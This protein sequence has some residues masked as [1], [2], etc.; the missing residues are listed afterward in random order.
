MRSRIVLFLVVATAALFVG[1]DTGLA[2][3]QSALTGSAAA[4]QYAEPTGVAPTSL[5]TGLQPSTSGQTA[6]SGGGLPFTGFMAITVLLIGVALA[7]AG[8]VVRRF[9]AP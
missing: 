1:T 8:I 4:A 3:V 9:S 2:Q 5:V 6:P 7:A